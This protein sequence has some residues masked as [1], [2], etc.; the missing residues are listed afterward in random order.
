MQADIETHKAAKSV[1]LQAAVRL[2]GRQI[3]IDGS[4][5]PRMPCRIARLD[6]A[7]ITERMLEQPR[8]R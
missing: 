3:G 5:Q 2:D 4:V 6:R 7:R 1:R 8:S